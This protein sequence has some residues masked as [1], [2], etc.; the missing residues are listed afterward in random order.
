MPVTARW[1]DDGKTLIIASFES[2]WTITEF[3]QVIDTINEMLETVT[4]PV[5][6][7]AQGKN[8]RGLPRG[9]N[10][11]PHLKRV[12]DMRLEHIVVVP[13]SPSTNAVL[14]VLVRLRPK[15]S[16]HISFTNDMETAYRILAAHRSQAEGKEVL[17]EEGKEV[18]RTED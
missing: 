17:S 2:S 16:K 14:E 3:S 15:W 13:S 6:A 18:L 11:I 5:Y 4:H 9:G 1:V 7:I 12:F 10:M 8:S